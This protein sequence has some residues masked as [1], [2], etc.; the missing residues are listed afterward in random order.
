MDRE[1][2]GEYTESSHT[3]EYRFKIPNNY[4]LTEFRLSEDIYENVKIYLTTN[5]LIIAVGSRVDERT[6]NFG[7]KIPITH[8]SD[9]IILMISKNKLKE[10]PSINI[11]GRSLLILDDKL[12]LSLGDNETINKGIEG[13]KV[14]IDIGEYYDISEKDIGYRMGERE[15]IIQRKIIRVSDLGVDI[16]NNVYI[17][18]P[19]FTIDKEKLN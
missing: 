19:E 11:I 12:D 9:G 14:V 3:H 17:N 15:R 13:G 7:I 1:I 10:I 6:W 4:L 8:F 2:R 18:D 5:G 16:V